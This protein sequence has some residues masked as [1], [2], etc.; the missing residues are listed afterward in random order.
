[1]PLDYALHPM[2]NL[3]GGNHPPAPPL[4]ILGGQAS[5]ADNTESAD[6]VV[7]RTGAVL[8]CSNSTTKVRLD[9]QLQPTAPNA[10]ASPVVLVADQ[11]RL[12]SLPGGTYRLRTLVYV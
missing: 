10:A 3:L 1:M 5:L 6:I 9:I 12:F 4:P 11:P 8:V 7:P 2:G